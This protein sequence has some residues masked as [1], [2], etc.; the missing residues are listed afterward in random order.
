[1]SELWYE[2]FD[3]DR[4]YDCGS[5][6]VTEEEI[7]EFARQWDPQPFHADPERAAESTYDGLIASGIHTIAICTRLV[8]TGLY[9]RN[10]GMGSPGIEQVTWDAPVRPGDTLTATVDI[11]EKRPLESRPDAGVVK[12]R[13]Q[14]HNQD[15]DRVLS[16]TLPVF[17]PRREAE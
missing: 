16:V 15:E 4:T 9:D 7:V 8:V 13:E 3:E 12:F 14:L 6:T 10:S 11:V 17:F 5:Y 2:E 1:M